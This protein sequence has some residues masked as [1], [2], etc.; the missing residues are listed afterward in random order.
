M[1]GYVHSW[2]HRRRRRYRGRT[3]AV[4]LLFW[5]AVDISFYLFLADTSL[6]AFEG[7]SSAPTWLHVFWR[8]CAG[9]RATRRS[10]SCQG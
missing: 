6:S 7:P 1:L 10:R 5:L 3:K 9:A 8:F 4:Y 2:F